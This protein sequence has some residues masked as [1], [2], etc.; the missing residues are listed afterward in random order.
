MSLIKVNRAVELRLYPTQHQQEYFAKVFGCTRKVWNLALAECIDSYKIT[1]KFQHRSYTDYYDEY[2]YLKE[3]ETQALCQSHC[4]LR[5]AFKNRFSKTAKRQTGFPKFKSKRSKQSYRTCMPSSTALG[6]KTVKIPK[7]GE[8][9]FHAKPK[10]GDNWKLKSITISKSPSGKYHASLL[11]EFFTEESQVE[12]DINNS[13]GLDY[14]SNGLFV[15][16]QGNQPNYPRYFRLAES[17]LAKEQRKLSLMKLGS[18]NYNKQRLKV[19]KIHEKIANQRKDFLHKLS[20][21]FANKYDYVFV[22]DINLQSISQF[23][24]LGKS[25]HDNG[26]GM[27]RTYLGYKMAE[28]SKVFYK[29]DRWFPSSKTCS[30]CGCYHADIVNSL[31]VRDWVCPDCGSV[32]NRDINAA[33]NIRNKGMND[34]TAGTAGL[35][36]LCC[37][38]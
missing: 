17:K 29:I 35:A 23:G 4:D 19:A 15:D 9:K 8:V 32:H 36:S 30:V 20:Y 16:N 38:H 27:F 34:I 5:T 12:L 37:E 2:P 33:N 13:I 25:T 28:R 31:D 24:H 11:Y 10:I 1:G 22:E 7:I 21:D 14:Q 3:V 6:N 26:F 18:N